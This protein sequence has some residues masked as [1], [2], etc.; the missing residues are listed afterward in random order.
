MNGAQMVAVPGD[1]PGSDHVIVRTGFLPGICHEILDDL[2][3]RRAR[4]EDRPDPMMD[5]AVWH[6]R[7]GR[8]RNR[9]A[10]LDHRRPAGRSILAPPW[11]SAEGIPGKKRVGRRTLVALVH[12][13][14]VALPGGER[15]WL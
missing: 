8:A 1:Q 13:T 5:A 3:Y 14:F 6:V 10:Q 4:H 15:R 9:G 2:V 11:R 12:L 7:F